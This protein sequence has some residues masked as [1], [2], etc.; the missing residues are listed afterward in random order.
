MR[1]GRSRNIEPPKR[2]GC[3][4]VHDTP[5][6]WRW[7]TGLP[8]YCLPNRAKAGLVIV[9]GEAKLVAGGGKF[10]VDRHHAVIEI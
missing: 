2:R 5:F 10:P 1:N 3:G 7:R 9:H 8:P 6:L 4:K